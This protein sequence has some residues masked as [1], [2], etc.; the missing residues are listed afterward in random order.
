MKKSKPTGA[1]ELRARLIRNFDDAALMRK[2]RAPLYD[3]HCARGAGHC[4]TPGL[5]ECDLPLLAGVLFLGRH[6]IRL[7]SAIAAS[8]FLDLS[9]DVTEAVGA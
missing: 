2:V 6:L 3:S 9:R 8:R 5:W 7:S 4:G 1:N